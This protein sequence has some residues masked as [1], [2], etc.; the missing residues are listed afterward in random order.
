MLHQRQQPYQAAAARALCALV[1]LLLPTLFVS[2]DQSVCTVQALDPHHGVVFLDT[3]GVNGTDDVLQGD[4]VSNPGEAALVGLLLKGLLTAGAD[5]TDIG[6]TSPYKAQVAMLQ[7]QAAAIATA[8]DPLLTGNAIE[9]LT[10]DKYQG[11]DKPCIILS[12]VRSNDQGNTGRLLADWQRINVAV[13]RAKHKLLLLGSATTLRA[14]PLLGALI[15]LVESR[16]WKVQLPKDAVS[17]GTG[18]LQALQ[19]P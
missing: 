1:A 10:V 17:A 5:P 13:T 3:S 18:A 14:T 2:T 8:C 7:R 9:A 19:V 4:G 15:E 6:L 16:G 11:R 12:F